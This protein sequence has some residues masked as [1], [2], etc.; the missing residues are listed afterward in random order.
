MKHKGGIYLNISSP[1]RQIT[2][3]MASQVTRPGTAGRFTVLPGHAPIISSLTEGDIEY[4]EGEKRLSVHIRSGF[5][6]VQGD[7][8]SAC[9]EI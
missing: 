4:L 3:Q 7:T 9:V 6:E 8:V 5:V 2:D 1:E